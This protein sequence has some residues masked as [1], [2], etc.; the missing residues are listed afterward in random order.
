[1]HRTLLAI[2]RVC[3]CGIAATLTLLLLGRAG[4]A[5]LSGRRLFGPIL[6]A[7]LCSNLYWWAWGWTIITRLQFNPEWRRW[8][9]PLL[10]AWTLHA[11]VMLSPI[12]FFALRLR[13]VWDQMPDVLLTWVMIWHILLAGFGGAAVILIG[14]AGLWR[15]WRRIRQRLRSAPVADGSQ[16]AVSQRAGSRDA[17]DRTA[18]D[19]PTR[20]T[21]VSA[22]PSS[23]RPAS[24]GL[25]RR[26]LLKAI[27][28]AAPVVLT[29]GSTG[30]GLYKAGRFRVRELEVSLPGLPDRL[31]G[32][33]I[34]HLSDLHVGRFFRPEHLP[35]MV[36]TANRLKGDIV[37]V[38]GDIIDHSNQFLPAAVEALS[39]LEAPYGRFTVIGNHDL[40][41]EADEAVKA[42]RQSGP[43]FLDDETVVADIGGESVQ[44]TGLFWSAQDLPAGNDPGYFARSQEA[45]SKTKEERFTIALTHHPHAFDSL[46]EAGADLVLAGHT[47]GGQLMLTP[48]ESS[49]AFGAG[50]LMFHY[51]Y[52]FY[53][54]G[55]ARMYVNAG[56]GNWFPIRINA[57]AEI[58]RIRLV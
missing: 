48:P 47:H 8:R 50:S 38:T 14:T 13:H 55:Q 10:T 32:L 45:M 6:L 51:I 56:V 11:A 43:R 46:A 54:L 12:G 19:D 35:H 7:I 3:L 28:A 52:G 4:V 27:T 40:M 9:I 21:L 41:D 5:I 24:H 29:A 17:G 2:Q 42:I 49:I 18:D 25:T 20:G 36:E 39:Q 15:L 23:D 16:E 44:I 58:V 22:T 30:V 53:S 1:M 37:A 26:G 33:T 57:P 31:K 34:T